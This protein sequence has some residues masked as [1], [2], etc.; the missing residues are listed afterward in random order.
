MI[1]DGIRKE[2]PLFTTEYREDIQRALKE[3][4]ATLVSLEDKGRN[5][6]SEYLSKG[7]LVVLMNALDLIDLQ[8]EEIDK[9]KI[10]NQSLRSAAN[11]H[12]IHY[13][14]TRA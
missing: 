4:E 8:Q 11:S 3:V 14:K 1:I 5:Y 7:S 9:M 6:V 13:S 10:E 12:K 2:T